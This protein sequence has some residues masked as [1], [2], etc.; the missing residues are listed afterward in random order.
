MN[1]SDSQLSPFV[2]WPGGK[3]WLVASHAK[4]FFPKPFR[5][6]CEPFLG[7]GAI[8]VA[9]APKKA[10]LSDLNDHLITT[11]RAVRDDPASVEKLLCQHQLQ[12]CREHYYATRAATPTSTPA[13]AARF[14]YLNRTCFN[15]IYRVNRKTGRFNVP[16]GDR[17]TVIFDTDDFHMWSQQLGNA[18]IQVCDFEESIAHCSRGDAL[19]LDPPYTVQ[20]NRNGFVR[21]NESLFSW[22]DQ[23][24]LAAAATCAAQ[25]GVHVIITNAAHPS[26]SRL[27]PEALFRRTQINRNSSVSAHHKGRGSFTELLLWTPGAMIEEPP[28][29][30]P[31]KVSPR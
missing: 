24:R 23:R 19:F 4:W 28:D 1:K 21:Y 27:Y 2:K 22:D 17:T 7:S 16:M 14:I 10:L 13:I 9:L 15:G 18:E 31:E 12:H 20:H 25:R 11:F 8:F 3:R 5:R 30:W 6:Y 29:Q 26:V